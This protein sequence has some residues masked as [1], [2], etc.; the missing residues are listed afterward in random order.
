MRIAQVSPLYESVPPQLYGG[1]E[2]IVFHLTEALTR[3]GHNVTLFASGDSKTSAEL[4]SACP[5]ALRLKGVHEPLA[6][7]LL[8]FERLKERVHEFDIIHFHTECMHLSLTRFLRKPH[9]S[10]MHGRLDL[11]EFQ[12][13]FWEFSDVPLVSISHH[14]RQPLTF[15]NWVGMVHHG[16]DAEKLPYQATGGDYLAF[17]GR[18]SPEKGLHHAIEIARRTGMRLKVAAKVEKT[19]DAYGRE[20]LPK[21]NESFV[22]F[23]GEISDVE[24]PEFLG[25]ARALLFPI[26]W[27]EPFGLVMIESMA[28]GTPVI[29]FE[30][31]SVPEVLRHEKTGFVVRSVEEACEAVSKLDR[32]ERA[33]CRREFEER[34]I[35]TRMARDYVRIYEKLI[36]EKASAGGMD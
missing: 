34:F 16:L 3:L 5:E 17:L 25:G 29:A 12:S 10:T 28:M 26:Q 7:H 19:D 9:V 18:V 8:L 11:P 22:E 24:K 31:G 32:I 33:T 35:S 6:P 4:V 2:R 15:A 21:L 30:N 27:P 23:V 20:V 1:T 36:A 13:L 14:Q